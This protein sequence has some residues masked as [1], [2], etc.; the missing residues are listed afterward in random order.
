V[1]RVLEKHGGAIWVEA[2]K[3]KGSTF[4]FELPGPAESAPESLAF[5]DAAGQGR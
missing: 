3:G 2:Q 4:Y 5:E 1:H